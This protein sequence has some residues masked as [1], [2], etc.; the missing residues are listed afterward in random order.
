MRRRPMRRGRPVA[1]RGRPV[2][3]R[4]G[5]VKRRTRAYQQGGHTHN[6]GDHTHIMQPHNHE[7]PH[8]YG[9]GSYNDPAHVAMEYNVLNLPENTYFEEPQTSTAGAYNHR[10]GL[11]R[12]RRRGQGHRH[13][14]RRKPNKLR[15]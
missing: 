6:V 8:H 4:R 9:I 11:P 15:G 2:N 14:A 13:P 5:S 1:R 12:P 3:K 7:I 10:T